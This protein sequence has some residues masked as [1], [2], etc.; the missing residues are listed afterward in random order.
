MPAPTF[1]N[2]GGGD[3]VLQLTDSQATPD[4]AFLTAIE[5]ATI[6]S[7]NVGWLGIATHIEGDAIGSPGGF[8][9]TGNPL[10]LIGGDDGTNVIPFQLA[11][12]GDLKI[13]LDNEAVVLGAGSASIGILGAN[14]GVDIGDVDVL[15]LPALSTGTNSIGDIRAI[16]TSIIPG[17]SATHLGKAID[18]AAA[19]TDTGVA[20]L[21]IRD[22]ALTTLTPVDGDYVQLRVNSTGALHVT[23]GGG[24]TQFNVDAALGATPEGTLAIALRDDVLSA[25]GPVEGDAVEFRV[26][27]NGALWTHDDALDALITG[28]QLRVDVIAALPTGTNSIGDIRAIT[29]SITPGGGAS[30]L[31]KAEDAL[32]TSGDVG[33]MALAVRGD[34]ETVLA[35]DG[36]YIPLLVNSVGRLKVDIVETQGSISIDGSITAANTTGDA[37][38]DAADTGNPVKFGGRAQEPTAQPEEVADNDRADG[39]FDRNGYLRVRGDFN[40]L[41]AVINDAVSGDNTIVAAAGAGKKI[42]VWAILIVSDGTVDVRWEDGAAGTALTGQVPLQAR[43]GYAIP[44]GGLVPLFIGSANTLLNLELSLAVNVHGFVSYTVIDD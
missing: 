2:E 38:H 9:T 15:S 16:T 42:A 28:T 37:A 31:G 41:S 10:V 34:S 17:T 40:P 8:S 22:D 3:K 43:E 1:D 36:D 21:A 18:S 19:G 35:A 39:L 7:I 12:G 25:L 11:S 30:H 4:S 14:S 6:A 27:A 26:D 33:V 5:I 24:G 29:T 44:A 13:T 20:A 32:H 23:G